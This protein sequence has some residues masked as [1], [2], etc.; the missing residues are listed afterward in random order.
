[1]KIYIETERLLLRDWIA[2]DL[3][4]YIRMNADE[5]VME[6]FL[7]KLSEAESLE[8]LDRIKTEI[9][10]RGFGFFAVERKEDNAFMGFVGLHQVGFDV[11]FVPAVEIG[12][13]LLPEFWGKGYTPEA[14]RGCFN[15]AKEQLGMKEIVAFTSVPNKKSERVMEKVGMEF[16]KLFDHPSVPIDHP[17]LSHVLYKK[18]L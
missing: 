12:W 8:M 7:S 15:F 13:R 3:V 16:V 9:T 5:Q 2:S 14:A 18:T 11:D 6:F 4:P 17:L 1:M 10:Q